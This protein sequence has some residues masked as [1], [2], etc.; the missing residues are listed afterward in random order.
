VARDRG[1]QRQLV[2]GNGPLARVP[3]AAAFLVVVAVFATAVLV[4]GA[5]GAVLLVALAALA[6]VLLAAAWP[7]LAPVERALRVVVLLVLVAV[8]LSLLA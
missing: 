1:W 7:R 8:A 3:P 6:G 2:P 4:G 5:L